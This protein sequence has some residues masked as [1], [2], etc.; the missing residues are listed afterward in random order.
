M[1]FSSFNRQRYR[2]DDDCL[3][4]NRDDYQNYSVLYCEPKSCAATHMSIESVY[5]YLLSVFVLGLVF[6]AKWPILRKSARATSAGLRN[7][8]RS[9]R[10]PARWPTSARANRVRAWGRGP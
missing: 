3:K 4:D 2:N 8:M 10:T 7:N 6:G 5:V 1:T 9:A